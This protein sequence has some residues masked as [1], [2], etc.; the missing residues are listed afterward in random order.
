MGC[1][2]ALSYLL[3]NPTDGQG[4]YISH[5]TL[6]KIHT[7]EWLS[8]EQHPPRFAPVAAAAMLMHTG[9]VAVIS[10]GAGDASALL[11]CVRLVEYLCSLGVLDQPP[12]TPYTIV[13]DSGTGT[14]AIG[15]SWSHSS[16]GS[17]FTPTARRAVRS[18]R[19]ETDLAAATCNT[20]QPVR[21]VCSAAHL[22]VAGTV[23]QHGITV[24]REAMCSLS[25]SFAG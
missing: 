19:S 6:L 10:E 20:L 3:H 7:N 1:C 5:P 24:L 12:G 21:S 16:T 14:T 18:S 13:I 15:E 22:D 8:S 9:Q 11:G 4:A 17:P 23:P 2:S 25:G